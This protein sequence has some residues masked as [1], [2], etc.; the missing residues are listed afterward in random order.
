[1]EENNARQLL[2]ITYGL[3]L[4]A[5]NEDG[6][7]TFADEFFQTMAEQEDV[8]AEGLRYHIGRH[9]ELLGK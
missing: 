4:Q 7:R 8:F 2:H 9:L 3:L 1:M 5:K 6:S